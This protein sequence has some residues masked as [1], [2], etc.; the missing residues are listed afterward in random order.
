MV[1]DAARWAGVAI[2]GFVDDDPD[3]SLG[4]LKHLGP[5]ANASERWMLC[6]GDVPTRMRVLESLRGVAWVVLHPA[7]ILS[8]RIEV[9]PGVF[10]GPGA[11][12]NVGAVLGEHA[13]VNSAAIVEHDV[14]V[15]RASHVAPGA[16]LCGGAVVGE[17]C[18]IGAGAVV[19]PGMSVG[20]GAVVGAG[21]VVR[22]HVPPRTV[23]V[24]VP[25]RVLEA[26]GSFRGRS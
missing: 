2:A 15:G 22:G 6:I 8:E 5:I 7:A 25:A 21:A 20:D 11:V 23:A 1:A 19:L 9:S 12:V 18:L 13:I 10:V 17:G 3:A 14:R 24:G 16:V 4:E 26:R